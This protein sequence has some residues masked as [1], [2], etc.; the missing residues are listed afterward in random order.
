L[1]EESIYDLLG[2]PLRL[3]KYFDIIFCFIFRKIGAVRIVVPRMMRRGL[4]TG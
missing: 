4:E 1:R 3:L 2:Q